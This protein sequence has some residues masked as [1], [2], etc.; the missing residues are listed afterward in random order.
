MIVQVGIIK[1]GEVTLR[2]C[3]GTIQ[4]RFVAL[5]IIIIGAPTWF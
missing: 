2:K 3:R 4:R 1:Q 5:L